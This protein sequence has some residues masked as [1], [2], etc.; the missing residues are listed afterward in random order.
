MPTAVSLIRRLFE[1]DQAARIDRPRDG[2]ANDAGLREADA[3]R[4]R[5]LRT[6][7]AHKEVNDP[8]SL[9][10]AAMVFQHGDQI[11]DIDTAH[12]L[13]MRAAEQGFEPARWLAAAAL[14]RWL[15]YRGRP[16]R[17]GT[18]IVPDGVRYRVWDVDPATSD[19]ERRRWNVAPLS[20]VRAEAER[21]TREQPMPAM[22]DLP[23][24][25]REAIER[26]KAEGSL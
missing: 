20:Q 15:M 8:L 24:W 13:A 17:F 10:R 23:V 2:T 22:D 4:R 14:D 26:W 3:E 12:R 16:Q 1:A 6:L 11:D 5:Q 9:Y 25:L 19:E 7:L 21:Q 18:Q